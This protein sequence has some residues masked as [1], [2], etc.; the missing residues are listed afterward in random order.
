MFQHQPK[1]HPCNTKL[2]LFYNNEYRGF[3]VQQKLAHGPL[4]E[5]YLE[6]GLETLQHSLSRHRPAP[7]SVGLTYVIPLV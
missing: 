6:R 3:A 1:R 4:I 7:W 2:K 5:N